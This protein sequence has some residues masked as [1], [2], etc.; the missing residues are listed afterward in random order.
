MD[1]EKEIYYFKNYKNKRINA[2][3]MYKEVLKEE[4]L[5]VLPY[6]QKSRFKLSELNAIINV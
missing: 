1:L 2:I 5:H 3:D 6:L 4:G